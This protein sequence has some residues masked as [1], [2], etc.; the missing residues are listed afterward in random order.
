MSREAE[1]IYWL[2]LQ[3]SDLRAAEASIARGPRNARRIGTTRKNIVIVSEI[4]RELS[5]RVIGGAA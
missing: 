5:A 4:L 3:L 1:R 2:R